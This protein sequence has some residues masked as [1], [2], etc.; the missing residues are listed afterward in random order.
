MRILNLFKRQFDDALKKRSMLISSIDTFSSAF[1][2]FL[3]YD[4]YQKHFTD[5]VNHVNSFDVFSFNPKKKLI[6]TSF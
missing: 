6:V 1:Y 5:S 2:N 4:K 3:K